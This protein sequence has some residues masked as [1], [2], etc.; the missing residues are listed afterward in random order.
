MS[1]ADPTEGLPD[2]LAALL[3]DPRVIVPQDAAVCELIAKWMYAP[4]DTVSAE[5]RYHAAG[6]ET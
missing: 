4:S 1:E 5:R 2:D 3:R 6:H